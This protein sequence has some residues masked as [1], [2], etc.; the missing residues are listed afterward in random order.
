LTPA[1]PDYQQP[2]DINY[3]EMW[4]TPRLD[5][6]LPDG[7]VDSFTYRH[8]F[9]TVVSDLPEGGF[10]EGE[11]VFV[12]NEYSP[13]FDLTGKI[14]IRRA[15]TA[16]S[17]LDEMILARDHHAVGLLIV[18]DVAFD[19]EEERLAKPALPTTPPI[20]DT[21]PTLLLTGD[22]FQRLLA[23]TG[24][25]FASM[26]NTPPAFPML[27][28][29]TMLVPLTPA[30]PRQ[31]SNVLGYIQGS[32]PA[33]RDEVVIIGAHYDHVGDDPATVVC[34]GTPITDPD[35]ET[36]SCERLAGLTYSGANDNASGVGVLL[37]IAQLW[38]E[39]GYRPA[40]T[41][42]FAAWGSQEGGEIGA[43]TYMANPVFPLTDTVAIFHL[44]GVG[45]GSGFR[46]SP[47]G[48]WADE[49]NLLF[50]MERAESVLDGRLSLSQP[51][52]DRLLIPFRG[53][54]VPTL[55]VGWSD[56]TELNLPDTE[57]DEVEVSRLDTS[58][59]MVLFLL[60]SVVE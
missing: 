18:A 4:T 35:D 47:E 29:A 39:Q 33:L 21:I 5:L 45:G 44:D 7:T 23:D 14:V 15:T 10:G 25:T 24:Q 50:G 36:G 56:A 17:L 20:T 28:N 27:V 31:T 55:F 60:Q 37:E 19:T 9:V 43:S 54:G 51:D 40:R 22:G 12:P 57:A 2:F 42:L 13:S 26:N 6:T 30:E 8:D 34:N 3:V 32:D 59:R 46:L 16:I 38:Q 58:G 53:L 52:T 49:G 11:L 1:V 48:T 41:V